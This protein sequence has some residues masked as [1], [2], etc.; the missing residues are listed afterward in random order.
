[1]SQR[2]KDVSQ[3]TVDARTKHILESTK[4][5]LTVDQA[6]Q[7]AIESAERINARRREGK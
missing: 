5:K 2:K 6:K 7:I 3:S 4:G 1:M